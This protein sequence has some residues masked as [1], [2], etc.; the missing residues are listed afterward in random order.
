MTDRQLE[1]FAGIVE[2]PDQ[3]TEIF[4]SFWET[5]RQR[6]WRFNML[7]MTD[8]ST[9]LRRFVICNVM[10]YINLN[11]GILQKERMGNNNSLLVI[12]Q[13]H[14]ANIKQRRRAGV[15]LHSLVNSGCISTL[16][17]T[18][19]SGGYTIR[20]LNS[21]RTLPFRAA[22]MK[23][24]MRSLTFTPA[25]YAYI[26]TDE[27]LHINLFDIGNADIRCAGTPQSHELNTHT[28]W[29]ESIVEDITDKLKRGSDPHAAIA[30]APDLCAK[31]IELLQQKNIPYILLKAYTD[32]ANVQD[33]DSSYFAHR[34]EH[35]EI[36][37]TITCNEWNNRQLRYL[38][39]FNDL[40]LD[41][42]E[43]ARNETLA[44]TFW[45]KYDED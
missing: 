14:P 17:R 29:I 26:M 27:D 32:T 24:A 15:I 41:K 13:A 45:R 11:L 23:I 34:E 22:M 6:S 33:Y 38:S 36:I 43:D 2:P 37:N 3:L 44:R 12:I 20:Y 9:E 28:E 10:K 39:F 42:D 30:L 31:T 40:S 19:P 21:H 8:S 1:H 5:N 7:E 18:E 25:E 16:F 4:Q 35:G